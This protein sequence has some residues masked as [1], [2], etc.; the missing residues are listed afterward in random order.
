MILLGRPK[1][2]VGLLSLESFCRRP[3]MRN[4]VIEGLRD[5]KLEDIQLD[6]LAIVFSR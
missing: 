4:S 3:E 5:R 6:I 2:M 1:C